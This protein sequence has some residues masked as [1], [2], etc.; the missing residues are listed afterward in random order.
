MSIPFHAGRIGAAFL[1]KLYKGK[2]FIGKQS[3]K[4]VTYLGNRG[5][6]KSARVLDVAAT[7]G[8]VAIKWADKTARKYPRSASAVGGAALWDFLDND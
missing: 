6:A 1:E 2:S 3:K 5:Y 4:G 7:K 8:N